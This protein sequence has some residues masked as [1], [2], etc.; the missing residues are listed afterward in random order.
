[1]AVYKMRTDT[2]RREMRHDRPAA[3]KDW[4]LSRPA[5]LRRA[6]SAFGKS[7]VLVL[8]NELGVHPLRR[9]QLILAECIVRLVPRKAGEVALEHRIAKAPAVTRVDLVPQA[10]R[11]V[12]PQT[13][14]LV[15]PEERRGERLVKLFLAVCDKGDVRALHRRELCIGVIVP[16]RIPRLLAEILRQPRSF[17][18][19]S[20]ARI[21][22][23]PQ[24]T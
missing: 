6:L 21:D 1:M 4:F 23:V 19:S 10:T 22:L 2:Q 9:V 17:E 16:R 8:A 5:G 12:G 11:V 13:A 20:M 3:V 24:Q 15:R 14:H 7:P 18:T